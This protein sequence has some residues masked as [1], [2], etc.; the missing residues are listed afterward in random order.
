[1]RKI[2]FLCLLALPFAFSYSETSDASELFRLLDAK[3]FDSSGTLNPACQPLLDE[4]NSSL[5]SGKLPDYIFSLFGNKKI[6]LTIKDTGKSYEYFIQTSSK[7][8]DS[9]SKG[10]GTAK[11]FVETDLETV[12]EIAYSNDW[13]GIF[14]N[15]IADKRIKY[16]ETGSAEG[17]VKTTAFN[18]FSFF[19]GMFKGISSIFGFR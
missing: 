19:A 3:C 14:V 1:M 15:A 13:A 7:N 11:M 12:N 17:A 8:V 5:D 6:N 9:I 16:S 18:I 4:I 2:F 10:K